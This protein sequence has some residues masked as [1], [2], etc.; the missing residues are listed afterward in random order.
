MKDV[1]TILRRLHW[2]LPSSRAKWPGNPDRP[3]SRCH[4]GALADVDDVCSPCAYAG[5]DTCWCSNPATFLDSLVFDFDAEPYFS[6]DPMNYFGR[7]PVTGGSHACVRTGAE[8]TVERPVSEWRC[9]CGASGSFVF[10]PGWDR[11]G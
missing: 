5:H 7:C 10:K 1:L 11:R 8:P 6:P 9:E 2:L 3:W 4:C